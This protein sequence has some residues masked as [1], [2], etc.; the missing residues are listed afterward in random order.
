MS[1]FHGANGAVKRNFLL[2]GSRR[3]CQRFMPFV[4]WPQY[5]YI[6]GM[7]T[8]HLIRHAKSSWDDDAL[9]DIDR[10]LSKRGIRTCRFMAGHIRDAGCG[11]D[12]VFCSPA[13]R[14]QMTI[15]LIKGA[16]PDIDIQWQTDEDLYTFDCSDLLTWCRALDDGI[17]EVTIVGHN[18]ASTDFCN[19][20]SKA[21]INNVP[22]CGYVQLTA[23]EDCR[24]QDISEM[25]FEL[26]TFLKPKK[27]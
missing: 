14:A 18:P 24:W 16:L 25:D 10:P 15:E 27:L 2:S 26:I 23:R 12:N 21:D 9:A 7:K 22:T 11:F 20:L 1:S 13:V 19:R 4:L 3:S 8:I 6:L 5:L 17:S